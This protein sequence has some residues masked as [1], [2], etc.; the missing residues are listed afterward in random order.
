MLNQE[1]VDVNYGALCY[2]ENLGDLIMRYKR[3][4]TGQKSSAEIE[5]LNES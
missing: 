2:V 3:E 4:Y 1:Q 5:C